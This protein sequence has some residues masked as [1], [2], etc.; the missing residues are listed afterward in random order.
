M[1]SVHGLLL[2]PRF[3]KHSILKHSLALNAIPSVAQTLITAQSSQYLTQDR[4]EA[5]ASQLSNCV[6]LQE[7]NQIYAIIIRSR[8]LYF[9]PAPFHWNNIIRA[10]T[11]LDAPIKAL[12]VYICMSRSGILPDSYTLPI[13]LKAACQYFAIEIGRQF[14]AVALRLGLELNEYCESGFI[15][16]YLKSGDFGNACKLFEENPDRKLGSWNAIISGLSQ[17]GRA[18]E[19]IEM[20]IK[21]RKCGFKPDGVTMVSV[22]SACG[23]LG[24]LNLAFQLHK[25]VFHAK[26]FE[27]PDILMLN[28]LVDMYGK[29]GRMDLAGRV[30]SSMEQKNVSSWTSMIV[31]FAMHGNVDEAI[32]CF[33]CMRE[34]GVRPNHVTFTGVL[35]ACVHGGKVKE[36]KYFFDMMRNAYDIM[37][38]IKHYGCMVDLLGRVGLLEEAREIVEGM[39]M[40]PNVVIWG[41][42][43]G[44]CEKYGD[45]KMGEWVAKHLQELEPWNEGGFVVLSNI[46]A[47]KGFWQ[48]VERVRVGMKMQRL[49]KIPA[50]SLATSTD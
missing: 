23:S 8:L 10:Y 38:E 13:I 11:R 7:L 16:L 14:H 40:K 21:M 25:Y 22:A 36:G 26:N 19:A 30:F 33:H 17:G 47:S 1:N 18:M 49:A 29:C 31:G 15:S 46:Y 34:A 28:S 20:F 32:E 37:P 35:S 50:Y 4:V 48:E 6:N 3:A 45:V 44:A 9:Y 27:K 5:I 43:M 39:P 42:L 24:D 2:L 12:K 41:C